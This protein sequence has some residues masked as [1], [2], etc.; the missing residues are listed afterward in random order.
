MVKQN[1]VDRIV[2]NE[3][4]GL[5]SGGEITLDQGALVKVWLLL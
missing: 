3:L 5:R 1:E 2:R 4:L